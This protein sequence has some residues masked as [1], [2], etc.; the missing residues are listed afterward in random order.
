MRNISKYIVPVLFF[1]MVGFVSCDMLRTAEQDAMPI[2]KPNETYPLIESFTLDNTGPIVEGDTLVYTLKMN[3]PIDRSLTFTPVVK[4]QT[5]LVEGEDFDIDGVITIDPWETE[6]K[7]VV[8][9]YADIK[10][11]DDQNLALSLTINSLAEKHLVSPD[12]VFPV[13]ETTVGNLVSPNLTLDVHWDVDIDLGELGVYPTSVNTDFDAIISTATGFDIND[14]WATDV[15][16]YD[17]ATGNHPEHIELAPGKLPD[18]E[19]VLWFDLWSNGFAG[20]GNTTNIPVFVHAYQVG[21]D[22][23]V[24]IAQDPSNIVNAN[25][26]GADDEGGYANNAVLAKI[27]I[28]GS[29]FTVANYEDVVQGSTKS[30]KAKTPR[31]LILKD[32]VARRGLSR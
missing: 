8:Y 12:N 29:K 25:E 6:G 5:T 15:G 28:A 17:G 7:M 11:E 3:R 31:P 32:N 10:P 24:W 20:Y 27:T 9:T 21:T 14:P 23:D 1:L 19:Y 26:P 2:V 4:E 16:I 22:F 18:G 13:I 30:G